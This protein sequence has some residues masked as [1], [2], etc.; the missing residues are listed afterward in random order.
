MINTKEIITSLTK[1]KSSEHI[2]ITK[3]D[4]GSGIVILNKNDYNSKMFKIIKDEIKFLKL[5]PVG[6]NLTIVKLEKRI[7]QILKDLVDKNELSKESYNLIRFRFYKTSSIWFT[8][9]TQSGY[10]SEAYTFYDKIS[11]T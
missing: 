3:P 10:T 8:K 1:I 5:G 9:T 7:I 6:D 4:K 11:T 2:V